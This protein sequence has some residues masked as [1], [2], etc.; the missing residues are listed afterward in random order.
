MANA[1]WEFLDPNRNNVASFFSLGFD[2]HGANST[3]GLTGLAFNNNSDGSP[4]VVA[5]LSVPIRFA[6][7]A[8][9]T[10]GGGQAACLF[11]DPAAL[12][13][14]KQGCAVLPNPIP[15]NHVVSCFDGFQAN[16]DAEMASPW[17]FTGPLVD[18][19]QCDE[20]VVD[21]NVLASYGRQGELLWSAR[22]ALWTPAQLLSAA[23][24][25]CPPSAGGRKPVLRLF[26]GSQ[27]A[28][29][30]TNNVVG[31]SWSNIMQAFVGAGC[32]S[33]T[34]PT[35]CMCRHVRAPLAARS[36]HATTSDS[37]WVAQLT[38]FASAV[39]PI[40]AVASAA[41]PVSSTA[42]DTNGVATNMIIAGITLLASAAAAC[43]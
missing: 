31:C 32:V 12:A 13:Y 39:V 35:Q 30:R 38:D 14:S 21:C 33:S 25:S 1:A 18:G 29:V 37:A 17:M 4:I 23:N 36:R 22:G 43:Y 19:G 10:S 34:A 9:N 8:V 11:W 42:R 2:P 7:P 20:A 26:F 16:S 40:N 28:L 15:P 6:L 5:N 3:T 24:V 41:A 27:C